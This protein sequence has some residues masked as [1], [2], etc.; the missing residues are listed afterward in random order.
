MSH[1]YQYLLKL[2]RMETYTEQPINLTL[3]D[4]DF[5][6]SKTKQPDPL[7]FAILFALETALL[8]TDA[9]LPLRGLWFHEALLTQLGSWPLWPTFLLFPGW[10]VTPPINGIHISA[11]PDIGLSWIE[12]PMLLAALLL[13]FVL[14][15]LALHRL[16]QHITHRYILWS[17]LLLGITCVLIPVV[18]SPD[19][20]SYIAYAR[21]GVIY[22]LNPL[23]T[24]PTAISSDP[25]YQHIYWTDQ[26][27]AYGPAWA[28]I[29]YLLQWFVNLFGASQSILPMLLAL[30]LLGLA[31]HLGSTYLIWSISGHLQHLSKHISPTRRIAATL[32]FAWNPLLLV[33]ACVNAHNDTTLLFLV[34]LA[35]WFLVRR[36]AWLGRSVPLPSARHPFASLRAG[37]ERS[38]GPRTPGIPL[39]TVLILAIAT[40]LKINIVLLFPGLLLFLW[41]QQQQSPMQRVRQMAVASA[42]YAS[43]IILLYVPFWQHGALLDVLQVNPAT[44]RNINTVAEFLG[45]L[46]DSIYHNVGLVLGY[47]TTPSVPQV[48]EHFFHTLSI[49]IFLFIYGWLCLGAIRTPQKVNTLPGLIRWLALAWLLYCAIGTPWFWPWYITIFFGFHSLIEAIT[50]AERSSLAVP[51]LAFSALSVYCFY[52][53][54]PHN[55]FIPGLPGFQWS[56]LRGLWLWIIPFLALRPYLRA[57]YRMVRKELAS[58]RSPVYSTWRVLVSQFGERETSEPS[59]SPSLVPV[60]NSI[61]LMG[62]S[63]TESKSESSPS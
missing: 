38:E 14:Y 13:T 46:Y 40:C 18:T 54:G 9:V 48:S 6:V 16:P 31:T 1:I 29:T 51:L 23:T 20:F 4:Q 25:V 41:A 56:Y 39:Q 24:A 57:Y 10:A 17:T 47:T 28:I 32:A 36:G 58:Y 26:P 19:I 63:P 60:Q 50:K 30:R 15:L 7:P 11:T 59:G 49:A 33:E 61:P 2:G 42:T 12:T 8:L 5:S 62:T 55:T 52:T 43:I 22:H 35:T 21:M 37:F 44:E 27:S 53:W 45:G 34:L 3:N